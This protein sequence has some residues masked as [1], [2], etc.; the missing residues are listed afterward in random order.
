MKNGAEWLSAPFLILFRFLFPHG[1]FTDVFSSYYLRDD[2]LLDDSLEPALLPAGEEERLLLLLLPLLLAELADGADCLDG[3]R[4]LSARGAACDL[5]DDWLVTAEEER[6]LFVL[7]LWPCDWIVADL[8]DG[9]AGCLLVTVDLWPAEFW[10]ADLLLM[11][12][13]D[14]GLLSVLCL[15]AGAVADLLVTVFAGLAV[16]AGDDLRSVPALWLCDWIVADLLVAAGCLLVAVVLCPAEVRSFVLLLT[17]PDVPGLLSVLCLAAGAV[18]D[19]LGTVLAG[20]AV[21]EGDDLRSAPTLWPSDGALSLPDMV[22]VDL[23][24]AFPVDCGEELLACRLLTVAADFLSFTAL[25]FSTDRF[26]TDV[27]A[28]LLGSEVF[29]TLLPVLAFRSECVLE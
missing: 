14:P 28:D 11:F 29:W 23:R 15:T 27:E 19:L 3:V 12:A 6:L 8:L 4:T 18:A 26:L 9:A 7:A 22:F 1:F 25:A 17:F 10:L 20:L 2:L 13:D 21:T 5:E 24:A 16:T